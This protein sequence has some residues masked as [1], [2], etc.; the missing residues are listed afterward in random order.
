MK[1]EESETTGTIELLRKLQKILRRLT[2]ITI[3]KSFIR[4][5]L[6]YRDI[7]YDQAY[8]NSFH[9]KLEAIQNNSPLAITGAITGTSN[10]K[11]YHELGL[12]SL[13]N[14]RW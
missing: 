3:Y 12:G 2:L 10:E 5:H 13:Q 1:N 4:L 6:D 11:H 9:Q 8:K 14:R 7:I